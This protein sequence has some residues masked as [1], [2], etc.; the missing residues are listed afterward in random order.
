MKLTKKKSSKKNRDSLPGDLS[1][2]FDGTHQG[3]H[4][5]FELKPKD[6]TISLRL[7]NDLLLELKKKADQLGIDY[8]KYIRIAL[9]GVI[10]KK[11]A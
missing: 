7:S 2:L 9:E 3:K 5:S 11:V 6:K 1:G 10:F 8:Q 4:V